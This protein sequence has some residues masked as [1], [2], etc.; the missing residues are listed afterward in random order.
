MALFSLFDTEKN[1]DNL[2]SREI[3]TANFRIIQLEKKVNDLTFTFETLWELLTEHNDFNE[4]ALQ[5]K[6]STKRNEIEARAGETTSCS[7]CNRT[8]PASKDSCYY[9]GAKLA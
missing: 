2:V 5:E 1:N 4:S 9:C 3:D 7:S 8:V 6:I